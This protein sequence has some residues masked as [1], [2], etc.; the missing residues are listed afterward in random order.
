MPGGGPS[1]DGKQWITT[2]HPAHKNRRKPFLINNEV[3]GCE[4]RDQFITGLRR[5]LRTDKLQLEGTVTWLQN[6]EQRNAWLNELESILWNV[7]IE[8]PPHGKSKPTHVIKY[9]ARYMSGGPIADRRL[10]SHE[11]GNVTFWARTKDKANKSK[12]FTLPG[13]AFVRHWSLHILPPGYTRSRSYGGFHCRKRADYLERC[14][15]LLDITKENSLQ[16]EDF[17]ERPPPELPKCDRCK[18]TMHCVASLR[19]PSWREIFTVSVYREPVYSPT[20]HIHFGTRVQSIGG[21]G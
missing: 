10:I 6:I 20:L 17:S 16:P 13:E 3:L 7:F 11:N 19:R 21:Y 9:L 18:E 14:R 15:Q 8:G 5:L 12:P 4:F 1:L 2:K